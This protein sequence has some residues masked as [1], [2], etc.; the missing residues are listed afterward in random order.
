[1]YVFTHGDKLP[2]ELGQIQYWI[3]WIMEAGFRLPDEEIWEELQEFQTNE[4][5]AGDWDWVEWCIGEGQQFPDEKVN[6]KFKEFKAQRNE[7]R[8]SNIKT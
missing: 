5:E 6:R 1:M 8:Q 7:R 2:K 4:V 3:E